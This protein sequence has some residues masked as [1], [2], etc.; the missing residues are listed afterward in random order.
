MKF[1]PSRSLLWR[2]LA[3]VAVTALA[4]G[5]RLRAVRQL[6]IDY[7]EDDYLAA[8]QRY[9]AALRT[10]DWATLINY[11]FNFEHP[12]L[13]KLAYGAALLTL[14]PSPDIPERPSTDPPV[15]YLPVPHYI[16]A[17]RLAAAF[18]T[19]EVFAAALLNPLAGLF[20]GLHTW[21]I[22][23]TSQIMLEPLPSFASAVM[24]LAYVQWRR[25]TAPRRAGWLALSALALGLT[26]ASKYTYCI[27]ALAIV[28]DWLWATRPDAPRTVSAFTRWLGPIFAWGLFGIAVFVAFDPRMWSHGLARLWESIAYH[29]SYAESQHVKDAGYPLW[30][31]LVWLA[32]PV[33]WH[34][35][36]FLFLLD[37]PISLLALLGL[38]RLWQAPGRRVLALWLLLDL[39]F[40]LWWNTKWPQYILTLTLP[41][42]MAA[43]EGFQ[44]LIGEPAAAWWKR[45]RAEGIHFRRTPQPDG[46]RALP[47]L[48]PGLAALALITLF[49]LVFQAAMALTDFNAVSFRDGLNGGVWRAVWQGLTGAVKPLAFSIAQIFEQ[50]P[51]NREVHFTGL[52]V[53]VELFSGVVSD[54]LLFNVMWM[55]LSVA[56]QTVL[57]VS[58]ALLLHR[59]GVRFQGG[60]R[61]IFIV[62]WA[63]P[64]YIGALIWLRLFEPSYGWINLALSRTS[65]VASF[66]PLQ[67]TGG[68]LIVLLLAATWYGFPLVLLAATAGLQQIPPEVYDAAALDGAAGWGLFRHV[69]WPMLWPLVAPA[70]LIRSIFAFNQ[71]YL[72]YVLQPPG[73][74]L[75]FA[76]LSYYIFNPTG[77]FGGWFAI[78]AAI[79]IFTVLV[80]MALVVW[81]G[82]ASKAAEGVTYA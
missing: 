32:G 18:G 72:F 57:G 33:P 20:L 55:A 29:A 30:Q 77:R 15:K 4:L 9:T 27:G 78:S 71:F 35:G 68:A 3:V 73:S 2:A 67:D 70:V 81:L 24:V 63:I 28:A 25:S 59:R 12:P 62:P 60:W 5:L 49:P 1:T 22:K 48:L 26:A 56:L 40:L 76:A 10:G 75:T 11:D 79:N 23:Y 61:A 6:P 34:P 58:V 53:L 38:R 50:L 16:Y 82:R 45:L 39:A 41:L 17:R 7:D 65:G 37:L 69:T 19:L 66:N 52:R 13:S 54:V 44:L 80:L 51:T 14:P 42:T 31:P 74:M 8:A 21:Q 43:A 46:R 47:W 36:V 64:E